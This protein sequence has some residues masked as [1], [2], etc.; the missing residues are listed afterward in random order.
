MQW[1]SSERTSS[2]S[3]A[4]N[5]PQLCI[6]TEIKGLHAGTNIKYCYFSWDFTDND[7]KNLIFP[8]NLALKRNWVPHFSVS[9]LQDLH[10]SHSWV[11]DYLGGFISTYYFLPDTMSIMRTH[12]FLLKFESKPP[13]LC[14]ENIE[15]WWLL[16]VNKI[17]TF[18]NSSNTSTC[19]NCTLLPCM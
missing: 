17:A 3:Y 2:S 1:L 4:S 19:L 13:V 8:V 6:N 5:S 10:I 14:E 7:C 16:S 9:A 11:T 12:P 18:G 15:R